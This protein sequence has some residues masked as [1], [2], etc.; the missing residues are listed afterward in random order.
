MAKR[1]KVNDPSKLPFGKLVAWNTRPIALGAIT[2]IIGYFSIYCTDTLGMNAAVVG[3]LLMASKILDGFTDLVAGYVVDNTK[4]KWG[5]ARPYEIC[6][7]LA[8][9]CTVLLFSARTEW[10]TTIKSIW[11]FVM[12]TLVFSIFSTFLNAAESPY[13]IRAFGNKEAVT[14]VSAI[15]GIFVTFGCMIVSISFPILMGNLATSDKGWSKLMLIY[16]IPLVLIGI[17]RFIFIKEEH[18]DQD[19]VSEHVSL[20]EM[21]TMLKNNKYAWCLAGVNGVTQFVA[22]LGAATYYFTWIVGDISKYSTLQIFSIVAL[23]V[24]LAFPAII[25]KK[26]A[27]FLIFAGSILGIV[28]YVLNFFAGSNMVLLIVAFLLGGI[29]VLPGSYL[30]SVLVMDI[31]KYNQ[32]KGLPSMEGTA[33]ALANFFGKVFTA[34]GSFVLG[35]LLAAGGYIGT[36]AVQSESALN[37][38]RVLYSFIPALSMVVML[39][40][41][42]VYR[43]LD[44]QLPEIEAE[45][46]R[47][48]QAE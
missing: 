23:L 20:K 16:A 31:A 4:T 2:I 22:G 18:T 28:G 30:R 11:I 42:V 33:A 13:I 27:N 35:I 12:Y 46:A 1:E 40:C 6:I 29:A 9:L 14:K 17:L 43:K 5:K 45:L 32:Y 39:L 24:M 19:A 15:G 21:F 3:T 37:M 44:N 47:R 8:W 25:R 36:Q 41:S 48:E 34:F 26:S 38:I 10:S 7:V